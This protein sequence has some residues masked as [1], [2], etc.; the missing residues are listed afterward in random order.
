MTTNKNI[1]L[2]LHELLATT[3]THKFSQAIKPQSQIPGSQLLEKH[4][5]AYG[6]IE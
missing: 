1:Q 4:Y 5:T 6:G 2:E 3:V